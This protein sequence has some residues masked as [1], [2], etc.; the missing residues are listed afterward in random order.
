MQRRYANK[1][2]A[3]ILSVPVLSGPL[4][5]S[6]PWGYDDR[7]SLHAIVHLRITLD[8]ITKNACRMSLRF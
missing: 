2:M 8:N 5:P 3:S 1:V 7:R 6:L 4:S